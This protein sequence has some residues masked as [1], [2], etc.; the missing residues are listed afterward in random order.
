[1]I[2]NKSLWKSKQVN[3][4]E[5]TDVMLY[6][7][8]LVI[9]GIRTHNISGDNTDSICSCKSNCHMIMTTTDLISIGKP[10]HTNI[11]S[12]PTTVYTNPKIR[13]MITCSKYNKYEHKGFFLNKSK[14]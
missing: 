12:K 4:T 6:R 1:M 3:E 5:L 7:V 13:V 9:C 8:H 10:Q 2:Q 11:Y 14:R